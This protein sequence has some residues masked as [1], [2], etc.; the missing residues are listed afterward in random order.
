MLRRATCVEDH[1]GAEPFIRAAC[2]RGPGGTNADDLFAL[3]VTGDRQLWLSIEDGQTVAACITAI[4]IEADGKVCEIISAGGRGVLDH[5]DEVA[6]WAKANGC[7]AMR[8]IGRRGW[9]RRLD[10]PLKGVIMEKA[11]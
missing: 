5:V 7:R 4:F 10:W 11:L 8:L 2:E 1:P 9:L 6:A 3:C